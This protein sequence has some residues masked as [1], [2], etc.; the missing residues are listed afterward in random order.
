MPAAVLLARDLNPLVSR[1]VAAVWFP[2]VLDA[3]LR[4]PHAPL[5]TLNAAASSAVAA[6]ARALRARA[7]H[8][9]AALRAAARALAI[10]L[11]HASS[12]A[13]AAAATSSWST[14]AAQLCAAA[15]PPLAE[16]S[17]ARALLM[18]HAMS[19]ALADASSPV[20]GVCALLARPL[21]SPEQAHFCDAFAAVHAVQS[22]LTRAGAA[23]AAA[24]AQA[25]AGTYLEA[26]VVVCEQLG[27]LLGALAEAN[28]A[29]VAAFAARPAHAPPLGWRGTFF[30][31]RLAADD[32]WW[33][34]GSGM[35]GMSGGAGG[36]IG[37]DAGDG[38]GA[39][40]RAVM[41]AARAEGT[42]FG[43]GHAPLLAH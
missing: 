38:G 41:A 32:R 26:G 24:R 2:S 21:S 19:A 25:P 33:E 15:A 37:G 13:S 34:G 40:V 17:L 12:S 42:H 36:G 27:A 39:V 1:F 6:L 18:A 31:S 28:E 35:D 9:A 16:A 23:L 14:P 43:A 7:L 10:S 8:H 4:E 11:A 22:F 29:R 20:G 30:F 3:T 5:A